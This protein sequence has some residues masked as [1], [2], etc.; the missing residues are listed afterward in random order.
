MNEDQLGLAAQGAQQAPQGGIDPQ[1]VA[2]V[3]DLL[4]SGQVTPEELIQQGIPPEVV[5]AAVDLLQ[6]E[7]NAQQAPEQQLQ[8]ASQGGLA[9]QGY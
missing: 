6:Q 7:I 1:M 3:K 5:Q 2:Q 8:Q 4:A 9:A